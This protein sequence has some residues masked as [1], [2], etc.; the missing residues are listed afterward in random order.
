MNTN[1]NKNVKLSILGSGLI[2]KAVGKV[3]AR[4]GFEVIFHDRNRAVLEPL[5]SEGC[6]VSYDLDGAVRRTNISFICVSS[7]TRIGEFDSPEVEEPK[8]KEYLFIF[9]FFYYNHKI[10]YSVFL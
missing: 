8:F 7:P 6:K 3:F 2:G 1:M 5:A 9:S 4:Y 10:L